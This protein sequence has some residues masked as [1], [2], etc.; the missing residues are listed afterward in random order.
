MKIKEG[1]VLRNVMGKYVAV[2]VGDTSINF[3]G[4]VNLNSTAARV[5]QLISEGYDRDGICDVMES[6]YEVERSKLES[7]V[8]AIIETLVS[9]GFAEL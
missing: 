6:E 1:F 9:G 5:W 4:M 7:D 2:A 3:R 8:D